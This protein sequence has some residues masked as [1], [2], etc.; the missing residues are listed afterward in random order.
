MPIYDQSYLLLPSPPYSNLLFLF[1][2]RGEALFFN[3]ALVVAEVDQLEEVGLF[4][5][6]AIHRGSV[7]VM[8]NPRLCYPNAMHWGGIIR[9][10]ITSNVF[11]VKVVFG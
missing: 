10:P 2:S 9:L 8:S 7:R 5:L 4:S 11:K 1:Y 3:Y 6:R